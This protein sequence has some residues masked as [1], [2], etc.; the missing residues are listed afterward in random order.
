[1]PVLGLASDLKVIMLNIQ[2]DKKTA[3]RDQEY[4]DEGFEEPGPKT[5]CVGRWKKKADG[6]S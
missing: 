3:L 5:H 2:G 1:M 4:Q 6:Y